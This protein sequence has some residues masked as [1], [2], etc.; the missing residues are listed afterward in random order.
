MQCSVLISWFW[1]DKAVMDI[2]MNDPRIQLRM[3]N[4]LFL[5]R[6][7]ALGFIQFFSLHVVKTARIW[8][9]LLSCRTPQGSEQR[10]YQ[11]RF[12]LRES[13]TNTHYVVNTHVGK[14]SVTL[15]WD[16]LRAF[17][18]TK[19]KKKMLILVWSV[20]NCEALLIRELWHHH[21]TKLCNCM[22]SNNYS[23]WHLN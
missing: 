11:C 12:L 6:R 13:P 10:Y 9:S 23:K 1:G 19:W 17:W 22:L 21:V 4:T 2:S 5:S 14:H 20:S 3:A 8:C 18:Q 7:F 15:H 16:L